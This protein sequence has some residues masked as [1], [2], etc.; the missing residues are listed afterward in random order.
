M[1]LVTCIV[2][3]LLSINNDQVENLLN[4]LG[5]SLSEEVEEKLNRFRDDVDIR[6]NGINEIV[7][8]T[9]IQMTASKHGKK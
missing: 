2:S 7:N 8:T 4:K 6:I 5:S 9:H 3:I 1:K